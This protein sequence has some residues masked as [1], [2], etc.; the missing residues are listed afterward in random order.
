MRGW[1]WRRSLPAAAAVAAA[2]AGRGG[3]E[4][5]KKSCHDRSRDRGFLPCQGK[6]LPRCPPAGAGAPVP[7]KW[8]V[9]GRTAV[10]AVPPGILPGAG[11]MGIQC[12]G[13]CILAVGSYQGTGTGWDT[14]R[15]RRDA[16]SPPS[17]RRTRVN[18]RVSSFAPRGSLVTFPR[19]G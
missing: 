12:T 8:Q 17:C 5:G 15:D 6:T 4:R 7:G 1:R 9:P 10:P 14:R 3:A 2:E 18:P 19:S 11:A 13:P 16:C